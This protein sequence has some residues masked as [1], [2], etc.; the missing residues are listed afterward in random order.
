MTYPTRFQALDMLTEWVIQQ[1][2][3]SN[4]DAQV[5]AI[6]GRACEGEHFDAIWRM[7][8]AYTEALSVALG[9]KNEWLMWYWTENDMGAAG[10]QAGYHGK[11]R[12]IKDVRGLLWLIERGRVK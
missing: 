1:K 11:L 8:D 6:F 10:M 2:R 4:L 3:L 7:F 9:D 12:K 5:K